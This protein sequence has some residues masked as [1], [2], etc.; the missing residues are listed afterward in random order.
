M[1]AGI[2][3]SKKRLEMTGQ[4]NKTAQDETHDVVEQETETVEELLNGVSEALE[5]E[6]ELE[7]A[8]EE[9]SDIESLQNQLNKE[10]EL[11]QTNKDLALRAQAEMDNLRKRTARD[12]ENAHKYAL[13]KFVNELLPIM[14]S[15]ELGMSAAESA[16]NIDDLREGMD[17]TIKMFNAAMDK[18]NVKAVNPQGEKFNPEQH[19][20]V[21]M[22]EIE[23]AESGAVVTVMQKGYELNGRLV[24][25]AMVVVAK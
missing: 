22:Q 6:G 23:G 1:D 3:L 16:E 20:A 2:L 7:P 19:E 17:L 15:L 5:I 13:E 10:K 21:S 25:P 24:R 9:L 4:E 18:F 8:E 14:D 12:V 11:S